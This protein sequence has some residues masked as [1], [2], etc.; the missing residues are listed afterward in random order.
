MT[1]RT[2]RPAKWLANFTVVTAVL[3]FAGWAASA[4][5]LPALSATAVVAVYLYGLLSVVY[6]GRPT[7][8]AARRAGGLAARLGKLKLAFLVTTT[9]LF[10]GW[11]GWVAAAGVNN[12]NIGAFLAVLAVTNIYAVVV[13]HRPA[14]DAVF[15]HPVGDR[16]F[17]DVSIRLVYTT[18]QGPLFEVY[19]DGAQATMGPG[20]TAETVADLI[21]RKRENTRMREL[22]KSP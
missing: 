8:D 13:D 16:R 5:G 21:D 2:L 6:L 19:I 11:A 3:A 1:D 17:S 22:G 18:T 10:T 15:D 20:A 7:T 12:Y 4:Y 9:L 14:P